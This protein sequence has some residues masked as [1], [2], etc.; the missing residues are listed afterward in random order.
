MEGKN[1]KVYGTL[2][3]KTQ[4]TDSSMRDSQHNDLI[5][6]AYQLFDERFNPKKGSGANDAVTNI[7]RYQDIIN[8]R[9]TAIDYDPNGD[10]T[11]LYSNLYVDGDTN[12]GG[13]LTVEGD[14]I[15]KGDVTITGDVNLNIGLNDLNDVTLSTMAIGQVLR[16]DGSEWVNAKLSLSDLQMPAGAE[17]KVLK[18]INGN[19]VA[20]DDNDTKQLSALTDVNVSNV[21]AGNVLKYNGTKWVAGTDESGS[22]LPAGSE[23]KVL[24]YINGQW[25]AA[26]DLTGDTLPEGSEGKVLKYINGSWVAADDNDTKQLSALTDV[27]VSNVTAGKFLKYNGSKWVADTVSTGGGGATKLSELS[28]VDSS[29]DSA[30]NGQVLKFNGTKWV[31]AEDEVGESGGIPSGDNYPTLKKYRVKMNLIATCTPGIYFKI[32][33]DDETTIKNSDN[34]SYLYKSESE[35]NIGPG[36]IILNKAI[37]SFNNDNHYIK[38][39]TSSSKSQLESFGRID[40]E[41][42]TVN[43][44][45]IDAYNTFNRYMISPS[46]YQSASTENVTCIPKTY[47]SNITYDYFVTSA[48]NSLTMNDVSNNLDSYI[49]V[50]TNCRSYYVTNTSN[51]AQAELVPSSYEFGTIEGGKYVVYC[52]ARDY[53]SLYSGS[54]TGPYYKK[55]YDNNKK[56]HDT[57]TY[58][59][60]TITNISESEFKNKVKWS[61]GQ[62]TIYV[63]RK[64]P[65]TV[66]TEASNVQMPDYIYGYI[67]TIS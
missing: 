10:I 24:K 12:I 14:S 50:T 67:T 59:D 3:N 41:K 45:V 1:I 55:T 49:P 36:E 52:V 60:V 66:L 9:L 61:N 56:T 17:G 54:L 22:Q 5:A 35:V 44:T 33:G 40:H 2:I 19:W 46:I 53:Q 7:D 32:T 6:V 30:T 18:Y 23:G 39:F 28:D 57:Y 15:F 26:D 58:V 37:E 20:G 25:V 43:G 42:A 29:V 64:Y 8:K 38:Y 51:M 48:L 21:A 65:F 11:N 13:D 47:N 63:P 31:A 16:Y 27:N 34:I 62:T 4:N